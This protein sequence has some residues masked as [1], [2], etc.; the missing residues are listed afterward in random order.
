MKLELGDPVIPLILFSVS[1]EVFHSVAGLTSSAIRYSIHRLLQQPLRN[2][3]ENSVW[4]L[5][6]EE[7]YYPSE[8]G[9]EENARNLVQR[10][11]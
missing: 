3:T 1:D 2:S 10:K 5:V 7:L 6:V 8:K 9:K 4:D 11:S